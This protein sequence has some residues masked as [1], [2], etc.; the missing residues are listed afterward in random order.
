MKGVI[1]ERRE[2]GFK[3]TTEK[4]RIN[5]NLKGL[6]KKKA[7]SMRRKDTKY[8]TPETSYGEISVG[9]LDFVYNEYTNIYDTSVIFY[10]IIPKDMSDTIKDMKHCLN[11]LRHFS[12]VGQ[13]ENS[14]E[15]LYI[16]SS[17]V[18][19][20]TIMNFRVK[21]LY[22]SPIY[23][24]NVPLNII[25][26]ELKNTYPIIQDMEIREELSNY[27]DI[28]R[29]TSYWSDLGEGFSMYNTPCYMQKYVTNLEG[30][31]Y[32]DLWQDLCDRFDID[33][34]EYISYSRT[35]FIDNNDNIYSCLTKELI[36]MRFVTEEYPDENET[37]D[38]LLDKDPDIFK[39][40]YM[41]NENLFT[42]N[43]ISKQSIES[44][45]DNI[46]EAID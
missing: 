36:K 30:T 14:K 27:Y 38:I 25:L 40:P 32:S 29:D 44:L 9:L 17:T 18:L 46:D 43:L 42:F 28:G 26:K 16:F 37:I 23:A 24:D 39:L 7:V 1:G 5:M 45:Y 34:G 22:V 21:R 13:Y 8:E 31:M 41:G 15:I 4:E 12:E 35:F 20:L 2:G 6:F 3:I 10:M 19:D 33:P 11:V